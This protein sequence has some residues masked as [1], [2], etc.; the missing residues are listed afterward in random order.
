MAAAPFTIDSVVVGRSAR[1][2]AVFDFVRVVAD[3]DIPVLLVK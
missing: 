2:R 3:S 1:M